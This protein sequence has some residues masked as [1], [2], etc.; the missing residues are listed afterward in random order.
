VGGELLG[1]ALGGRVLVEGG[2]FSLLHG[3]G[4]FGTDGEAEAG[5]VAQLLLDDL[6][7]AVDDLDRAFGAR[8]DAE[9]A[10]GTEFFVDLHDAADWH[11]SLSLRGGFAR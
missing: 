4:S 2:G 5:A 1:D 6:G 8:G 7:F 10:P 3:E 11:V 9:A